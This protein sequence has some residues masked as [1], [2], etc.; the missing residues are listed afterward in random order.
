MWMWLFLAAATS[1]MA[2]ITERERPREWDQLVSGGRYADRFG[3]G[4]EQLAGALGV[5]HSGRASGEPTA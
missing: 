4:G 2:Q 1:S 3:K 5:A